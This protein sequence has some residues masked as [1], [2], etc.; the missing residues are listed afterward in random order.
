MGQ[1]KWLLDTFAYYY[2]VS[3]SYAKLRYLLHVMNVATPTKDY[4][5]LV[6]ELL[7]PLI[8]AR[9]ERSLTRRQRIE[10]F[11]PAS[12][13]AAPALEPA[14]QVYYSL[15][16]ILSLDAQTILRNYLQYFSDCDY[17]EYSCEM[18]DEEKN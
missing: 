15:H 11:G 4:L 3:D 9:S 13:S 7:E 1:W 12:V 16:D 17:I 14:I 8:K 10:H 2:G 18:F 6:R 5:E